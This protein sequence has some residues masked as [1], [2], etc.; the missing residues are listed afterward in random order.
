M[1]YPYTFTDCV[2]FLD[3][4]NGPENQPIM[5]RATLTK[6]IAGNNLEMLIITDFTAS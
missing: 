5:R 6:T 4:I 2:K 1:C 3:G